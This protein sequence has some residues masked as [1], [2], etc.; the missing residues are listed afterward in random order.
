MEL[1]RAIGGGFYG[2]GAAYFVE[3]K[4]PI[5]LGSKWSGWLVGVG[6][7]MPGMLS[8]DRLLT[9]RRTVFEITGG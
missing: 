1:S 9:R 7:E 4:Q 6:R 8:D 2:C 5:R 3:E